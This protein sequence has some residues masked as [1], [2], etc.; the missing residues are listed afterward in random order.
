MPSKKKP[1][2]KKTRVS[3]HPTP[4]AKDINDNKVFISLFIVWNII[5]LEDGED[6]AP[7][8]GEEEAV[9]NGKV[10]WTDK[11]RDC[12]RKVNKLILSSISQIVT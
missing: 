8:G 5:F 6:E 1:V 3:K 9:G 11:E 10:P 4:Q 2:P 12:I 7:D